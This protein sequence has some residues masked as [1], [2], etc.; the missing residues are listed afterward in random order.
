MC[1]KSFLYI[2]SLKKHIQTLHAD[3]ANSDTE[4][5]KWESYVKIVKRHS[6]NTIEESPATVTIPCDK[7]KDRETL[8]KNQEISYKGRNLINSEVVSKSQILTDTKGSPKGPI[9]EMKIIP[10]EYLLDSISK[11]VNAVKDGLEVWE[12]RIKDLPTYPSNG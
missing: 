4:E 5:N 7:I 6:T 1:F 12:K 3:V 10:D 11:K 8:E 2:S 9:D